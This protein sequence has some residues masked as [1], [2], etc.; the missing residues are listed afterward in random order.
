M[1]LLDKLFKTKATQK[2]ASPIVTQEAPKVVQPP[3]EPSPEEAKHYEDTI[4]F[5]RR[6]L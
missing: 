3:R 4:N 5:L 1:G 6:N 2:T